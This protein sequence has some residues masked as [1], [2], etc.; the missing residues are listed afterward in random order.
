MWSV[1]HATLR[2]TTFNASLTL[3]DVAPD[4]RVLFAREE[5]RKAVFGAVGDDETPRDLSWQDRSGV[6]D[7]SSDGRKILFADRGGVYLR[8][9]PSPPWIRPSP[10]TRAAS[11]RC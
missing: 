6:A 2:S 3:W 4:G 5:E 7:L 1:R 10:P 8:T 9:P 11:W